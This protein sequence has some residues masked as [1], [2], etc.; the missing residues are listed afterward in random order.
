[1]KITRWALIA[2]VTGVTANLLLLAMF[3]VPSSAGWTGPANDVIGGMIS[4]AATIPVALALGRGLV[5]TRFAVA[6]MVVIV[7]LSVLLVAGVIPFTVQAAGIILPVEA[8]FAWVWAVGRSGRLS[9]GLNRAAE[10]IGIAAMVGAP[11]AAISFLLPAK[12]VLQ[13]VLGGLGILLVGPAWFAFPIWL[14]RIAKSRDRRL[15]PA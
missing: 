11:L 6:G 8:M 3:T 10:L 1:M 9:R 4:T 14:L 7:L 12:S 13:M 15:V 5:I 2:G